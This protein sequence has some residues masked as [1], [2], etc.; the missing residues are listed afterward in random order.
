MLMALE[1]LQLDELTVI[2][3]GKKQYRLHEKINVRSLM[4][5]KDL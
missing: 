2:Y 3:P 1:Q 5:E 4:K